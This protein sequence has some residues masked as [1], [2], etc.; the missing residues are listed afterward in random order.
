MIKMGDDKNYW[1][2]V[3]FIVKT[4][5]YILPNLKQNEA[6]SEELNICY[7]QIYIEFPS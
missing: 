7:H 3:K 5:S 1:C 2:E 4:A 6:T